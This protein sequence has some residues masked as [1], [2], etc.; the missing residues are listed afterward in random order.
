M[1]SEV[2]DSMISLAMDSM[3]NACVRDG[4]VPAGACVMASDGTIYGGCSIEIS[5]ARLS[6]PAEVVAMIKAITDGKREFD[7]VAVIADLEH[8]YVPDGQ[9][10]QFLA[11]FG[12]PEVIM[13]DMNGNVETV[14]L[15]ELLPYDQRRRE[16]KPSEAFLESEEATFKF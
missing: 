16:N 5:I 10:L 1:N 4:D 13:A 12:V 6:L 7:A 2:L 14:P 8:P 11:E 15:K 3:R 9:S